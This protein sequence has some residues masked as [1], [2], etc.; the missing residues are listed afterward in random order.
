MQG[1]VSRKSFFHEPA[2][3]LDHRL[4]LQRNLVFN[5]HVER[6]VCR[7]VRQS[8]A[9]SAVTLFSKRNPLLFIERKPQFRVGWVVGIVRFH[10]GPMLTSAHRTGSPCHTDR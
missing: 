3:R 4:K 6:G 10:D 8:V 1:F 5:D 9:R 2:H 7:D